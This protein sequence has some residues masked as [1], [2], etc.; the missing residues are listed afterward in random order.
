MRRI[1]QISLIGII[2][3]LCGCSSP[4]TPTRK[5]YTITFDAADG[6]FDNNPAIKQKSIQVEENTLPSF[7]DIPTKEETVDGKWNFETWTPELKPATCD[8]TYTATYNQWCDITFIADPGVITGQ[9]TLTVLANTAWQEVKDT[10]TASLAK[11]DFNGWSLTPGGSGAIISPTYLIQKSITLYASYSF[12][13]VNVQIEGAQTIRCQAVSDPSISQND[14]KIA[15]QVKD[16]YQLKYEVPQTQDNISITVFDSNETIPFTYLKDPTNPI[17]GAIKIDKS[18]IKKKIKI[19]LQDYCPAYQV[20]ASNNNHLKISEIDNPA[21][22]GEDYT[23]KIEAT[24]DAND[25]EY[26][27]PSEMNIYLGDSK[28]PLSNKFY[29][30][31]VEDDQKSAT[32]TIKAEK[33]IDDI[34]IKNNYANHIGYYRYSIDDMYGIKYEIISEKIAEGYIEQ[35]TDLKIKFTIDENVKKTFEDITLPR[36]DDDMIYMQIDDDEMKTINQYYYSSDIEYTIQ[37]DRSYAILTVHSRTEAKLRPEHLVRVLPIAYNYPL[38]ELLSWKDIAAISQAGEAETYFKVGDIKRLQ[39]KHQDINQ[40]GCDVISE[41]EISQTVRIIGFNQDIDPTGKKLGITFEF[42]DVL[43]DVNGYSLST[44][45][46]DT[47]QLDISNHDFTNSTIHKNLIDN[48]TSRSWYEKSG[49]VKSTIYTG[50]VYSMLPHGLQISIRAARKVTNSKVTGEW[51]ETVFDY[52]VFLLTPKEMGYDTDYMEK[53]VN[54][55]TYYANHPE[56]DDLIRYK[57]QVKGNDG[58][59]HR[60][61]YISDQQCGIQT[62]SYAGYNQFYT[63]TQEDYGSP[64]WLRSPWTTPNKEYA[65]HYAWRVYCGNN[66]RAS[67][68]YI[69]A[70]PIAP[71]F[72]L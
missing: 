40:D 1:K 12:M 57:H 16:D 35:G 4:D 64:Y 46:N 43:S 41:G 28:Y 30:V 54:I 62:K 49:E 7:T 48:D 51:I 59:L 66:L 38:I 9:T 68:D 32:V 67:V 21:K 22:K 47:N 72:C 53:N 3:L 55:Y 69:F 45:W 34:T 71:A 20:S 24:S 61:I 58:A 31:K 13:N 36:M 63:P 56:E 8:T 23:F 15:L 18:Y 42:V 25:D 26:F 44:I 27:V 10:P 29:S 17:Y 50:S 19:T 52:P 37:G 65:N 6:Y 70:Y 11:Y 60:E 5:N 14:I 2:C 33:I 39:L